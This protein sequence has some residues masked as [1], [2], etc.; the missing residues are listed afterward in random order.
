MQKISTMQTT[1]DRILKEDNKDDKLTIGLDLGD[2][3]SSYC[4]LDE[5]GEILREQKLPQ[6][7]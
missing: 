4:I 5:T 1:G 2:R 6:P 3:Y 7:R